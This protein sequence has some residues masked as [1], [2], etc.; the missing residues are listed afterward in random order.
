MKICVLGGGVIGLST[1]LC[2][3]SNQPD[4]EVTIITEKTTPYT[5]GDG[6]AGLWKPFLTH[7]DPRLRKWL[8]DTW[9]F[10]ESSW[11]SGE[12]GVMGIYPEHALMFNEPTDPNDD[13]FYGLRTM[14]R[15]EINQCTSIPNM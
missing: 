11:K 14:T 15:R 7:N 6:A 4:Q 10:A 9:N 13:M 2:I 3:K 12:A 8:E 1:A 5:T